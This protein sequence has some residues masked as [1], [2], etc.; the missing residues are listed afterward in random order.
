MCLKA[1]VDDVMESDRKSAT[2]PGV[3]E[4]KTIANGL[5]DAHFPEYRFTALELELRVHG[6]LVIW[7]VPNR[8][9]YNPIEHQW[10]HSK[11]HVHKY[12]VLIS[13]V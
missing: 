12:F 3:P 1:T 7:G 4:L 8:P 2:M 5:I 9:Q 13:H 11:R 6:H 10:A